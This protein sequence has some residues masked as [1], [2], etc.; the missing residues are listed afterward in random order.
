MVAWFLA[1]FKLFNCCLLVGCL[2][3]LLLSFL[4]IIIRFV[5][6][7]V[8]FLCCSS[9]LLSFLI[10]NNDG[11]NALFPATVGAHCLFDRL[12]VRLGSTLIEDIQEFGKLT[13]I[14]TRMSASPA[15]K[16]D[17]GQLGFG[18]AAATA[19]GSY[20]L[21]DQH[22]AQTIAASGSKRVHM[23]FD[24][25]GIFSGSKWLPLYALGGQGLQGSARQRNADRATSDN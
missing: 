4:F 19:N 25:S 18:T 11:T 7:A 12:T 1:Q 2:S 22:D 6:T 21:A 9:V 13:E 3:C 17:M 24:L 15:K 14:M 16:M 5:F 23:K 10:T 20:F 8:H